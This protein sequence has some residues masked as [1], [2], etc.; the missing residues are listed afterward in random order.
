[1]VTGLE[2][3]ILCLK[4]KNLPKGKDRSGLGECEIL[5]LGGGGGGDPVSFVLFI[6][7]IANPKVYLTMSEGG[8]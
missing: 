8:Y 6:S 5:G 4:Y 3:P 1:M 2:R 7:L